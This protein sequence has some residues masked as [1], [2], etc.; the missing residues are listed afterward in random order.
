VL[1]GEDPDRYA[2][3]IT[4]WQPGE[5]VELTGQPP[6]DAA[7]YADARLR[8]GAVD[9]AARPSLLDLV[10]Y[11]PED[12]LTKVD[13]ASMAVSLEVRAP[14]LDHRV[15]ELALRMPASAKRSGAG[16]KWP[17]RSLLY[18]HVPR[19]LVDRPKMGFGVPLDDWFRGPLRERMHDY[20]AGQDLED[21]GLNPAPVRRLWA[22]FLR[23]RS[24]RSDL[25]WQMFSLIGW[26]RRIRG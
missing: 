20:C 17:L 14:L 26:R 7:L 3:F 22:D 12:I 1:Q 8:S 4:W 10:S 24:Y 6:G 25:I 15:V 5:I 9:E 11:L 23:G 13:R 21:L 2:R 18:K 19:E 16:A